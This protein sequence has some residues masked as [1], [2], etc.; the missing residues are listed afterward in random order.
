[1]PSSKQILG[2]DSEWIPPEYMPVAF[3]VVQT[4]SDF[5]SQMHSFLFLYHLAQRK[6]SRIA[7]GGVSE[8]YACFT[9]LKRNEQTLALTLVSVCFFN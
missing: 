7:H 3:V 9:R 1:M 4:C 8:L 2:R 6:F 5:A